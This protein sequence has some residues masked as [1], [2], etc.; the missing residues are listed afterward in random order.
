MTGNRHNIIKA[1]LRRLGLLFFL[2][3]LLAGLSSC[4]DVIYDY[5]GDC[6]VHYLVN[7]RY[8]YNMLEADAFASQVECITLYV[9]DPNGNIVL[10]Q[11]DEGSALANEGYGMEIDVPAGTYT[12]LA[13]GK[14]RSNN[15]FTVDDSGTMTDMTCILNCSYDASG[16]PYVSGEVDELFYGCLEGAEFGTSGGV[17]YSAI[18]PLMKDTNKVQIALQQIAGGSISSEDFSFTIE[19]DDWFLRWDNEP[20]AEED[21]TYYA[22]YTADYEIEDSASTGDDD[23]EPSAVPNSVSTR[24]TTN[25]VYAEFNISRIMADGATRVVVYNNNTGEKVLSYGLAQLATIFKGYYEDKKYSNQEFLDR[26][27]TYAITFFLDNGL[28]WISAEINI[29]SWKVVVQNTGV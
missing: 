5:E 9:I 1:G 19:S 4:D 7:F 11:S 18:V 6:S 20:I 3:V 28:R 29:G 23:A 10:K 25:T 16:A 2:P 17:T 8:D 13:W 24:A 22:F 12:L 21:L 27:D 14:A 26:E 15:S